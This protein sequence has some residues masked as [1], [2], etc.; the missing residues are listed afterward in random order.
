[1]APPK[2]APITGVTM[3]NRRNKRVRTLSRD[4]GISTVPDPQVARRGGEPHVSRPDMLNQSTSTSRRTSKRWALWGLVLC[5]F[6]AP[7]C[8]ESRMTT[9]YYRPMP[10]KPRPLQPAP[11]DARAN[12]LV[13][14]V[15]AT[16]LDTN[17]NG[18]PDL[19]HASAHLF[20]TRYAPAI[21][22]QGAFIFQMYPSGHAGQPDVKPIRQWRVADEALQQALHRSAFG[23]CYSF[24][25]S[26]LDDG[27]D[28]LEIPMADIVCYFVPDD[29]GKPTHAGDVYT[30]AIG[31]R[32]LVPP[33]MW[34]EQR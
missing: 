34:H 11:P 8:T 22:E 1:M 31:R 30:V 4:P 9:S 18:Y 24:R 33:L 7:A 25:L 32:V 19:I 10:P 28:R 27:S 5:G 3:T 26:L 20:D 2:T 15:S 6:I 29:G 14:N 13:L 17:G 21:P 16:P 23:A 12:A